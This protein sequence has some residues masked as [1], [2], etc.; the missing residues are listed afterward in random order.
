[1]PPGPE[2]AEALA[3]VAA[4]EHLAGEYRESIVSATRA[5]ELA[6]RI[7]LGE[8]A[9]PLGYLGASQLTLGDP[10]G[11]DVMRRAATL[12]EQGGQG[13]EAAILM[14]NVA[15]ATSQVEGP[16]VALALYRKGMEFAERR[17]M[18]E[19][20]LWMTAEAAGQMVRVGALDEAL[21][22]LRRPTEAFQ[23]SGRVNGLVR[24]QAVSAVA[25]TYRG[26]AAEALAGIDRAVEAATTATAIEGL[27]FAL[28]IGA[29]VHHATGDSPGARALLTRLAE[30]R[31]AT[32]TA[33]YSV[34]LPDAVR[35]AAAV[36]DVPLAERLIES[37][38]QAVAD[39]QHAG[40]AGRAIVAEARRAPAE[41]ADLYAQAA[42]GWEGFG[43]VTERA[44]ALLGQGRC[45]VELGRV[46]EATEPLRTARDLFAAIGATPSVAETDALLQRTAAL[47][48]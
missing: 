10:A 1:V 27:I 16:A 20:T 21:S 5:A 31:H 30:D 3:E 45:L 46:G 17:G 40:A 8:R 6:E 29:L 4:Q 26:R 2:L 23:A 42:E 28:Q 33:T 35:T 25:L 43:V 14:N 12:A 19:M 18:S 37:M 34:F 36:G 7:G 24:C 38:V 47:A 13:R 11:L 9:K 39:Q 22:A 32:D 48:S 44:F 15:D 41:A